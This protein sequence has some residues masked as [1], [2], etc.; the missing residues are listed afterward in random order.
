MDTEHKRIFLSPGEVACAA[1]PTLITTVLGSCV[2]VTLWDCLQHRGGV[3]HFVLPYNTPTREGTRYGEMAIAQLV[4]QMV[5]LGATPRSL[6]AKVFGGAGV[7]VLGGEHG[8]VGAA[9]VALAMADLS[10]RRIPVMACRTGGKRG[11]LLIFDTAT[12]DAFVRRLAGYE[13]TVTPGSG[14]L[15]RRAS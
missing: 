4:D 3:N 10:R 9:N 7:L 11:R 8:S 2:A 5:A 13:R 1:E 6:Q 15:P 14:I 12:G